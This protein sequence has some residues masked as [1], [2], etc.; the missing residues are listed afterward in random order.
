M[1]Q[2]QAKRGR[3]WLNDGSCMRR[4]PQHRHHVWFYDF[5]MDRTHDGRA[6][7]ML[8]VIDE[9]SR[10]CLAIRVERRQNQEMVLE[11]LDNLFLLYGPPDYI[12]TDNV[13]EFAATAVREWRKRLDV[14]TL[15]IEPGSPSRHSRRRTTHIRSGGAVAL[16]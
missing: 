16:G 14:Q 13:A 1:L 2:Q 3:L 12:R 8:T 5:V 6:F 10:E 11:T 15:F 7:R 4:R 9:Y